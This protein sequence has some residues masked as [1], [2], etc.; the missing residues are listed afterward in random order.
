MG[1]PCEAL[2]S[3]LSTV[4]HW[5]AL[6]SPAGSRCALLITASHCQALATA[7]PWQDLLSLLSLGAP[8]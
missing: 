1:T 7:K 4:K 5:Q 8:C 6:L 2:L 3:L